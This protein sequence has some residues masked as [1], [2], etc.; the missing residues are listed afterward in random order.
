MRIR[1]F[2]LQMVSLLIL[3]GTGGVTFGVLSSENRL[4]KKRT[5]EI[6]LLEKI[7][8]SR[9]KTAFEGKCTIET[10]LKGT[11]YT[12]QVEIHREG[13]ERKIH[14]LDSRGGE[15]KHRGHKM[16]FFGGMT[17]ADIAVVLGSPFQGAEEAKTAWGTT[18]PWKVTT[19]ETVWLA[20]FEEEERQEV[21]RKTIARVI[22]DRVSE[23]LE[24]I[25]QKL[26]EIGLERPPAAGVVLTGGT[27]NLPGLQDLFRDTLGCPVKIGTPVVLAGGE[28]LQDP[29]FTSSVGLLLWSLHHTQPHQHFGNGR[30]NGRSEVVT[31][32]RPASPLSRL[33]RWVPFLS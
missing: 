22:H 4:R 29:A 11:R 21:S 28:S 12:T 6:S 2:V 20:S 14:L 30:S 24:I 23:F 16:R 8:Q 5:E 19:A 31:L 15:K 25:Q 17:N 18:Q 7:R 32:Q 10:H 27:A 13:A 1:S 3:L 9:L 33:G 26:S